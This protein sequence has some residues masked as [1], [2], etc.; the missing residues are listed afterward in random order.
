MGIEWFDVLP[1][2]T[3]GGALL[4]LA[5]ALF[6]FQSFGEENATYA[7]YRAWNPDIENWGCATEQML[8]DS[9]WNGTGEVQGRRFRYQGQEHG[10]NLY[11]LFETEDTN[12][13]N[14]GV[15]YLS[16]ST[17]GYTGA[18][19]GMDVDLTELVH[20]PFVLRDQASTTCE[21]ALAGLPEQCTL[22]HESSGIQSALAPLVNGQAVNDFE[23]TRLRNVPE[24]LGGASWK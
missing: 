8:L 15:V 3:V 1:K 4:L 17:S 24:D 11:L 20:C 12:P 23:T 7:Y 22:I 6:I 9:D 13:P 5:V 14:A 18:W 10:T 2:R 19:I 16:G 21:A